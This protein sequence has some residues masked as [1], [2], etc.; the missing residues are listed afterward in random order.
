MRKRQLAICK[1]AFI[2]DMIYPIGALPRFFQKRVRPTG[3]NDL[4][5]QQIAFAIRA[6]AGNE[7]KER[8]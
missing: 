8:W 6:A 1:A 4:R 5:V 7:N 2:R 3:W